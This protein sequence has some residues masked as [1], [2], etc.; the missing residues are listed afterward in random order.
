MTR[1]GQRKLLLVSKR[2]RVFEVSIPESQGSEVTYVDQTTS[3]QPPA[4]SHLS[5]NGLTLSGFE[6]AVVNL[7]K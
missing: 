5:E 7:S 4:S 6:V 1:Q 2:N 3:F